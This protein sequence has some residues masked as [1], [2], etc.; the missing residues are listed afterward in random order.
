MFNIV[1]KYCNKTFQSRY[2]KRKF[3]SQACVHKWRTGKTYEEIGYPRL[4]AINMRRK[5]VKRNKSTEMRNY[6]SKKFSGRQLSAEWIEKIR[7]AEMGNTNNPNIKDF[8]ISNRGKTN[9]EIY[10]KEKAE[11]IFKRQSDSQKISR[12]KYCEE[13]GQPSDKI[14]TT[15]TTIE[16]GK[17]IRYIGVAKR[18][19]PI[20]KKCEVCNK[21]DETEYLAYHHWGKVEPGPKVTPGI[22]ACRNCH[23]LI[24]YNEQERYKQL[25]V[26]YLEKK[27]NIEK[28]LEGT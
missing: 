14:H 3:C 20:D 19:R 9:E 1:C 11:E 17:I 4:V 12:R 6:N 26:K 15:L 22:W 2:S 8:P 24:E 10:G 13:H 21:M 18:K 16:N 27:K 23:R 5:L 25:F 7:Q 28:E